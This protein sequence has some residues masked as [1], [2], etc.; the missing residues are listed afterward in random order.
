[1]PT[2]LPHHCAKYDRV[3]F[4]ISGDTA[5]QV[6]FVRKPDYE[7]PEF[8]ECYQIFFLI[9]EGWLMGW[10]CEFESGRERQDTMRVSVLVAE[11]RL[12]GDMGCLQ[13]SCTK[14]ERNPLCDLGSTPGANINKRKKRKKKEKK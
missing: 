3:G 2:T 8:S 14:G 4:S 1:M 11:M 7:S 6:V 12:P 9:R 10:Y 5:L 13:V